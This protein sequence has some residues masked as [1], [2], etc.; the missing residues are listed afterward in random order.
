MLKCNKAVWKVC[1]CKVFK[2]T[3]LNDERAVNIIA[4]LRLNVYESFSASMS[5]FLEVAVTYTFQSPLYVRSSGSS[6][7]RRGSCGHLS[8]IYVQRGRASRFWRSRG[9]EARKISFQL[10]FSRF[11]P[12]CPPSP[13]QTLTESDGRGSLIPLLCRNCDSGIPVCTEVPDRPT[14]LAREPV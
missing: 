8:F 5:G 3:P 14:E 9:R 7:Y 1:V 13:W 2:P 10:F 12:N 4:Y 6:A 11:L